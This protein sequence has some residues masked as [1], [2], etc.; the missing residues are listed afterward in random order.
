MR[1]DGGEMRSSWRAGFSRNHF[2]SGGNHFFSSSRV[3]Y[4]LSAL[5][6]PAS[7]IIPGNTTAIA[8]PSARRRCAPALNHAEAG[9]RTR[10]SLHRC[11]E[12]HLHIEKQSSLLGGFVPM[13]SHTTRLLRWLAAL[14]ALTAVSASAQT[15]ATTAPAPAAAPASG[16]GF[17]WKI[18]PM[19]VTGFID[20]YYTGNNNHPSNS[21]NGQLNQLYNFN[22]KA[23]AVELS[24]VKL[25]LHHDPAPLGAHFDFLYGRPNGLIN[26][27]LQG[28]DIEQAYL[29]LKPKNAKG[30]E[31]DFG[32]FVTSA[33][34][35]VVEAKDNWN[36]SRSLLFAWAIPYDHFGLRTSMPVS[37]TET[38]G[39]QVVNGWN[40]V[41]KNNGWAT[42]GL[43]SAYARPKYTWD[44]NVYTGP[45]NATP[46]HGYRNL[47]DTTVLLTPNSKFNAY[48]NYDFGENHDALV[49]GTGD[50]AR[51]T[52]QGV[53]LAA[54]EQ[55]RATM[56]I[57]GRYEFFRDPD[58]FA[59]GTA[60]HLNEFTATC[61]YKLPKLPQ[62]LV[63]RIE[64]RRDMSS[65]PFFHR[66]NTSMVDAQST[67]TIGLIAI[68]APHQ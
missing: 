10:L 3:P 25:T 44:L 60:Q 41:T 68:F 24:A 4:A 11:G 20:G 14:V 43:T 2:S 45:E 47:F 52:W 51:N 30:F 31:A 29:N 12:F 23:D 5:L 53:A 15:P 50:T 26:A 63:S 27:G 17:P 48:I 19:A 65:V 42:I 57:A 61:E 13:N 1:M 56:A 40:S 66:G 58:G 54:H 37:K 33:G 8:T 64:Y 38:V 16:P 35:E 46:T 55:F 28:N 62:A 22:D 59:T 36:Y 39:V 6:K 67:V 34:A 7:Y 18:G 9:R 49:N 21:A 32:K